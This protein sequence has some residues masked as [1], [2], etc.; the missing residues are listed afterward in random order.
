MGV[1]APREYVLSSGPAAAAEGHGRP[2]TGGDAA[3]H[4]VLEVDL[5]LRLGNF[6]LAVRLETAARRLV[7]FGPSGSGKSVTLRSIAGLERPAQGTV[8]V[9]GTTLFDAAAGVNVAPERRGIGY[10]PQS[11]AL[12][13]HLTVA[14]NVGYGLR[15]LPGRERQR[16]VE[17]LLAQVHLAEYGARRT[18]EL[19]GGEQQR[20]AL[21]RALATRTRLLL[22]D[23]PFSALDTPVRAALREEMLYL[24]ERL[25]FGW[26]FVTHDLEE[27]YM[28]ADDI[29]VYGQ[30]RV[31]QLAPRDDVFHRPLN[32]EVA[33]LVGIDNLLPVTASGPDR[34]ALAGMALELQVAARMLQPR[35]EYWAC[36]RPEDIRVIRKDRGRQDLGR[37]ALLAGTIERERQLGLTA[38]LHV[39]IGFGP[40]TNL[41]VDLPRQAYRSLGV[42][43]DKSWQLFIP[44]SAIH[45][46]PRE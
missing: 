11:A 26:V 28:L 27:A 40:A 9:D 15:R 17:E 6:Q 16:R 25:E 42:A 1:D 44:D 13:P 18:G 39:R 23:E 32:L 37:G 20:A 7:L 14:D 10:V 19:S 31:L 34:V 46:I 24:Q 2:R 30:G 21:A 12:F 3:G 4:F 5:A 22:L 8:R 41:V 38:R 43:T 29:A 33:R 36:I 45:I 35:G